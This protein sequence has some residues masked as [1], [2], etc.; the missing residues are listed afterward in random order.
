MLLVNIIMKYQLLVCDV[1]QKSFYRII[2][3]S[4]RNT[5]YRAVKGSRNIQS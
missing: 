3:Q 4:S 5:K 1:S 2:M